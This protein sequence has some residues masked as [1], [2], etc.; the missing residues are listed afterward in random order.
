M[1]KWIALFAL[2]VSWPGSAFA[3]DTA[4]TEGKVAKVVT[5][6][7]VDGKHSVR[8]YFASYTSDRWGCLQNIGYIEANDMSTYVDAKALDRFLALAITALTCDMT[9]E[10]IRHQ[11]IHAL[12]VTC[13]T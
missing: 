7:V 11:R 9:L 4:D 2:L 5:L 12:I 3:A 8:I 6:P 13:S 10:L 1:I